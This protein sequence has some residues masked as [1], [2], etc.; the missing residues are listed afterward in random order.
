LTTYRFQ[1]F[2]LAVYSNSRLPGL[3]ELP[4][5]DID[6]SV[7]FCNE[8]SVDE[9]E[10]NWIHEWK[11]TT[12]QV[13]I[14]GAKR[15]DT[16]LLRFPGLA[17]YYLDTASAVIR[18][19]PQGGVAAVTLSHLLIDQVIPRLICHGGRMVMHASAVELDPGCTVAFLGDTGRGKSTLASSY[20]QSGARLLTDDCLLVEKHGSGLV[21]IPAYPSLRLWPDSLEEMFP[22]SENF[23]AMA[24]YTNK[25]QLQDLEAEQAS[26]GPVPISMLFI[27]G[28]ADKAPHVDSVLLEPVSGTTAMMAMIESAFALDVVS[29]EA[30]R[31][32]FQLVAEVAQSG[33][34]VFALNY[35]RRYQLLPKVREAVEKV[36]HS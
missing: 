5:G 11:T 27:L 17:D 9:Q 35:A 32:N 13:A 19:F 29:E 15:G 20:V 8:S 31:R 2:D 18:A 12:G 1:V 34:P 7:E 36:V 21:G 22:D 16:Y 28:E 6:I 14:A 23:T 24:H 10:F 3:V 30:V 4:P 33:V 25:R 26:S